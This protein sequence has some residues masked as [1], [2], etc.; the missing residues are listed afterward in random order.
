MTTRDRDPPNDRPDDDDPLLARLR[1]LPP[2]R[3]DDVA[4]ARTL[5][6]AEA[7]LAAPAARAPVPWH[8]RWLVPAALVVWGALYAARAVG[9]LARV[10]PATASTTVASLTTGSGSLSGGTHSTR[11]RGDISSAR[12]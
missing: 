8:R 4:A 5:A 11:A 3:L 9:E 1:A 6:R 2:A 12:E 7:A 10:Y